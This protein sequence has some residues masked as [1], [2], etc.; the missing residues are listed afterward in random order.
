[1]K[2]ILIRLSSPFAHCLSA[3]S[4]TSLLQ[5]RRVKRRQ[6]KR[7]LQERR[8]RFIYGKDHGYQVASIGFSL[9]T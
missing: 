8:Y 3:S 9:T 5:S 1:M 4:T 7:I 6:R 2:A